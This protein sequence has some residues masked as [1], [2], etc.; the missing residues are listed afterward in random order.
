MDLF[1]SRGEVGPRAGSSRGNLKDWFLNMKGRRPLGGR[2]ATP[3]P[4]AK[5]GDLRNWF[6]NR[7][8]FGGVEFK[9]DPSDYIDYTPWRLF[10]G[11]GLASLAEAQPQKVPMTDEQKDYIYDY[12][13]DFMMKQKMQEQR[14]MEGRILPFNY[15]GLEV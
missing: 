2:T 1:T 10:N 15:E 9:P 3:D 12:M 7:R 8:G 13:I 5:R 14:E 4:Y 6:L 11:G